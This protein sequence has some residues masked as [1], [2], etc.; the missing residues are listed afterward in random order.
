MAVGVLHRTSRGKR[1]TRMSPFL[2][3]QHVGT[4]GSNSGRQAESQSPLPAEA[5]HQLTCPFLMTTPTNNAL[6]GSISTSSKLRTFP[7]GSLP[8][9]LD[10]RERISNHFSG[11]LLLSRGDFGLFDPSP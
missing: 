7:Y 6:P 10:L 3:F 5:S 9:P 1:K 8:K 11:S 2:F 4:Q